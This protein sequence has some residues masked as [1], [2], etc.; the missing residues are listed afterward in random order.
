M[1]GDCLPCGVGLTFVNGNCTLT[2]YSRTLE[3]KKFQSFCLLQ[4]F[5]SDIRSTYLNPEFQ[6]NVWRALGENL[7]LSFFPIRLGYSR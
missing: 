4:I 5:L 7:I 1:S 6:K 3:R 2:T